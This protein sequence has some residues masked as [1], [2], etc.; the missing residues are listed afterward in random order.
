MDS[1]YSIPTLDVSITRNTDI[2]AAVT[3]GS[4][5]ASRI[6][7]KDTSLTAS[8]HSVSTDSL[9]QLQVDNGIVRDILEGF[10]DDTM[11]IPDLDRP[12]VVLYSETTSSK[13]SRPHMLHATADK[14][15]CIIDCT[16]QFLMVTGLDDF[17]TCSII[18]LAKFATPEELQQHAYMLDALAS[19]KSLDQG[20]LSELPENKWVAELEMT[21]LNMNY[22]IH[23]TLAQDTTEESSHYLDVELVEIYCSSRGSFVGTLTRAQS[24]NYLGNLRILVVDDSGFV[25]KVVSRLIRAE[26]HSVDCK[27]DGVEAL[28]ALKNNE[29]DAVIMDIHMPEMNG[30]EASL[31]F[32]NHESLM[33]QYRGEEHGCKLKII[34]MS[35][36][37]SESLMAEV[38]AAGFD[39]FISKPLTVTA[40]RD[41][42]LKPAVSR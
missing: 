3:K 16:T 5:W 26:G 14:S 1:S 2:A 12:G 35:S 40:F 42:K 15:G 19:S 24:T 41:L 23:V 33:H 10:S 30:L 25:L 11:E 37:S 21:Y 20:G 27:S 4:G 18:S 36:D 39:G 6:T 8:P 7:S 13:F 28:E 31:E 34:A 17:R 9:S 38:M 22:E 32:R 29:Y